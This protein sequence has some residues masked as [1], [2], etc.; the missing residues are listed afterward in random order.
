MA[1]SVLACSA[2]TKRYRDGDNSVNVLA[3]VELALAAGESIAIVGRSGSGKSTLLNLLGGLDSPSS[4]SIHVSGR[5]MAVMTEEQR[6]HWR[7]AQLGFVFQF[8]HL[9]PEFTALEAVAMP[10]R[11]GGTPKDEAL[12]CAAR[13]LD[14]VGLQARQH[15]RPGELSG[16]ERQRVAIARALINGPSCVLMDEPTGNLDPE[17]AEQ[18]LDLMLS[19]ERQNSAFIVVTHDMRIAQRMDRI[20]TLDAGTLSP[21]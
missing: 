20:L 13:L 4:G 3:G 11:I 8:H 12:A 7:N 19:M 16:G 2:L 17:S 9:L 1:D 21:L 15:H 14:R 10:A 18:V 6:C 5:D